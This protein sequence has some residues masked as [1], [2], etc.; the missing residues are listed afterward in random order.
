MKY[1]IRVYNPTEKFAAM[2]KVVRDDKKQVNNARLED[3]T[4]QIGD[5]AEICNTLRGRAS[6]PL[7]TINTQVCHTH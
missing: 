6:F 4:P 2:A 5:S 7:E 3:V 1:S